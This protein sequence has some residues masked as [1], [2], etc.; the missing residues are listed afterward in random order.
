MKFLVD[1]LQLAPIDLGVDLGRGDGGVT[2]HFLNNAK[3]CT[4]SQKVR[5]KGVAELMGMHRFLDPGDLC[6]MT[7]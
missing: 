4:A 1:R 5:G 6:I 2:E 3:V 7:Y